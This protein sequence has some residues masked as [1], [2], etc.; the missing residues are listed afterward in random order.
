LARGSCGL[1]DDSDPGQWRLPNIKELSSLVDAGFVK[2]SVP[3]TAGTGQWA[4][5]DPFTGVQSGDYY[6]SS[7]IDASDTWNAWCVSLMVGSTGQRGK[8]EGYYVWPVRGG[9]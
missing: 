2:P 9:L 3:N 7:T 4:A 8:T 6:R 1:T 5:G